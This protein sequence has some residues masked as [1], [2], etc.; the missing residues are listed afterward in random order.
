[1][2][3]S[4]SDGGRRCSQVNPCR[5][6]RTLITE[7]V[8]RNR[9]VAADPATSG[10]RQAQL[11]AFIERDGRTL[12]ILKDAI[13][14]HGE[15]VTL[16]K[17]PLPSAAQSAASKLSDSSL[18][19]PVN[20]VT[21]IEAPDLNRRQLRTAARK[22]GTI[23]ADQDG[24]VFIRT[25]DGEH[26]RLVTTEPTAI[27]DTDGVRVN[28]ANMVIDP[29]QV[30]DSAPYTHRLTLNA[31]DQDALAGN[32]DASL[33]GLALT[34]G[35]IRSIE[36]ST[37]DTIRG[38][39]DLASAVSDMQR[40]QSWAAIANG[41]RPD[42]ALANLRLSRFDRVFPGLEGANTS[43][44][45]SGARRL[46][47]T[48]EKANVAPSMRAEM[49]A[50]YLASQQQNPAARQRVVTQLLG[51]SLQ[52]DRALFYANVT[53]HSL[54]TESTEVAVLASH[55]HSL[56]TTI[57][58]RSYV[59]ALSART[60]TAD[61]LRASQQ[62]N[63]ADGVPRPLVSD[64]VLSNTPGLGSTP[65]ATRRVAMHA[66]QVHE[67]LRSTP[68]ARSWLRSRGGARG[69]MRFVRTHGRLF[70]RLGKRGAA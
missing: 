60:A 41:A 46:A 16:S 7:R 45:R 13:G 33:R 48:M 56:G 70:G 37:M 5:T 54:P 24:E 43:E 61:T 53:D 36:R 11:N 15:V 52:Q 19:S 62:M 59:T 29:H 12:A 32:P 51:S 64:S 55:A 30:T 20:T 21:T 28:L 35:P 34:S 40:R 65:L 4:C 67:N 10:E 66:A 3:R 18:V 39:A 17:D 42:R 14:T 9:R 31:A 27:Y 25:S 1:M 47:R 38:N 23:T 6:Y 2:C 49:M 63:V 58:E 69:V 50:G 22:A 44:F 26:V 68:Q 57:R 8:A